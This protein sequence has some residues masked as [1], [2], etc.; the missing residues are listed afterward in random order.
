MEQTREYIQINCAD[1]IERVLTSHDWEDMHDTGILAPLPKDSVT[2]MYAE[3][4]G[5]SGGGPRE[6][7]TEHA[8]LEKKIGFFYQSILG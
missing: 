1:Y 6:G 3:V 8:I 2:K 4:I 5:E 7:T